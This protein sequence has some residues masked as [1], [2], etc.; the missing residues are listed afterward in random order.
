M[1]PNNT[2][3]EFSKRFKKNYLSKYFKACSFASTLSLR[4]SDKTHT[5]RLKAK[6]KS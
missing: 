4:C 5:K 3:E 1:L 6:L 2:T